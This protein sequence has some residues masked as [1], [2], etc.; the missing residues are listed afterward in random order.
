MTVWITKRPDAEVTA[1]LSQSR[2]PLAGVRLAVK[3]NVDA[4]VDGKALPLSA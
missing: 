2:G 1:E 3:D 4:A